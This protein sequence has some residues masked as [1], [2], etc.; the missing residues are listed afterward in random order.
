MQFH[1]IQSCRKS[2]VVVVWADTSNKEKYMGVEHVPDIA[3]GEPHPLS[4][5]NMKWAMFV[6]GAKNRLDTA[7]ASDRLEVPE[8]DLGAAEPCPTDPKRAD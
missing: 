7:E 2:D 6:D 1:Y 3:P 8:S 4:G 5:G